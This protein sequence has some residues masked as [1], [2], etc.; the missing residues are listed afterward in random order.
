LS[1]HHDDHQHNHGHSSRCRERR[2]PG[3]SPTGPQTRGCRDEFL[4]EP[5]N[6]CHCFASRWA[7]SVPSP[8]LTRLAHDR[9]RTAQVLRDLGVVAFVDDTRPHPILLITRKLVHQRP[10]GA[11]VCRD[12]LDRLVGQDQR[13]HAQPAPGRVLDATPAATHRQLAAGD[14]EQP[15]GR[16]RLSGPK[17]VGARERRGERLGRQVGRDLRISSTGE[18]VA[19]HLALVAAIESAETGGLATRRRE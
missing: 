19:Q 15:R 6:A 17:A 4:F 8:R 3:Q 18:E 1:G 5:R 7:R 10:H 11:V 12:S 9:L 2:G 16:R 14:A 13:R